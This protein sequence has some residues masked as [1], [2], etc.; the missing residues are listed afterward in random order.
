MFKATALSLLFFIG[1]ALSAQEL[2]EATRLSDNFVVLAIDTLSD[3]TPQRVFREVSRE[4]IEAR[5]SAARARGEIV[6]SRGVNI[7]E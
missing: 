7:P 2:S 6:V 3:F 1:A 4:E 5:E